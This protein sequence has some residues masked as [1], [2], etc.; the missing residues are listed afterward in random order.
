MTHTLHRANGE[1][2]IL[3]EEELDSIYCDARVAWMKDWIRQLL[4]NYGYRTDIPDEKI[5]E[6]T[7][8]YIDR[9]IEGDCLGELEHEAFRQTM[10]D[11][12]PEYTNDEDEEEEK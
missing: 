3:T 1:V 5:E 2:V 11:D 6:I 8:S 12:Y 9:M 10:E 7:E 4:D